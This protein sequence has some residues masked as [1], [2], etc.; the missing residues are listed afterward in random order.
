[1]E[2]NKLV[3]D[4]KDYLLSSEIKDNIAKV[5]LFGSYAKG[6]AKKDSDIDILIF[7]TDGIEVKKALMDKIYDFMMEYNAP[8]EVL[9]SGI[10]ELFL[11][12]DYFTYNITSYGLE[13]YSMEK[14]EIK[15]K[16]LKDVKN[17]AEEYYESAQ[18][19]LEGDRIR[20]AVDAAHNAAELAAK[21]LILLKQDDLPGSHGGIV[22]LFGQLYTKTDELDKAIGRGL[23]EA[24]KL[25]NLARYKAEAR[26]TREDAENVLGLAER[27]IKIASKK[28]ASDKRCA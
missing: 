23:N 27:L 16:M 14:D 11:H 12:Q 9:I 18:E 22:S 28:I 24:L 1:M 3:N 21:G 26:L 5:I 2:I 13:I 20:L 15:V 25:R 6:V 8:L 10:D 19:A 17:L 4:L 7:T